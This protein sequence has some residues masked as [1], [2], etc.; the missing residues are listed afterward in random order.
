MVEAKYCKTDGQIHN[1]ELHS[2]ECSAASYRKI[3]R[4][5]NLNVK[6][7]LVIIILYYVCYKW[8]SVDFYRL[9]NVILKGLLQ[10]MLQRKFSVIRE[11]DFKFR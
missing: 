7:F 4:M 2:L 5:T 1:H 11:N 10:K 8:T 6:L 9:E 3:F